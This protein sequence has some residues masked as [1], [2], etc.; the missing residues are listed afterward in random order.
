MEVRTL[1]AQKSVPPVGQGYEHRVTGQPKGKR[2]KCK[3]ENQHPAR[4]TVVGSRPGRGMKGIKGPEST[5]AGTARGL[6][7]GSGIRMG[8]WV[9]EGRGTPPLSHRTHGAASGLA[10]ASGPGRPL[11]MSVEHRFHGPPTDS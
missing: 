10:V 6:P 1:G 11:G 2:D 8:S 7:S 3:R 9:G 4:F 5:S